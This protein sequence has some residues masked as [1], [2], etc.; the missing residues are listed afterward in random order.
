MFRFRTAA[1]SVA[2]TAAMVG[3]GSAA[4]AAPPQTAGGFSAAHPTATAVTAADRDASGRDAHR[5]DDA[6]RGDDNMH[7]GDDNVHR[8]DDGRRGDDNMRRGDDNRRDAD[9]HGDRRDHRDW[10]HGR[11]YGNGWDHR[12]G[13]WYGW[14]WEQQC[15]WAWYNDPGWYNEY[16]G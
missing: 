12:G 11:W 2:V 1:L 6:R 10:D 15:E 13:T 4:F 9:F 8:G 7:R 3:T 16:C 5:S 14:S